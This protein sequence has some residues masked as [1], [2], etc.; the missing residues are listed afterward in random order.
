MEKQLVAGEPVVGENYAE[1]K[2]GELNRLGKYV[3]KK[4]V[5]LR[6]M[7]GYDTYLFCEG[8]V[9][10]N[11]AS[12]HWELSPNHNI[13]LNKHRYALSTCSM[14]QK[15]DLQYISPFIEP[16]RMTISSRPQNYGGKK[17]RSTKKRKS[18]RSHKRGRHT[19]RIR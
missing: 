18:K 15:K 11:D 3:G 9:D 5:G 8:E 1:K 16:P 14:R 4:K 7:G 17:R 12:E 2:K 19:K 13:A 6:G 10:L